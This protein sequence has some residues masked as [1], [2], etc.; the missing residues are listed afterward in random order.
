[1]PF[2]I[3]VAAGEDRRR[4]AGR[5]LLAGDASRRGGGTV[6]RRAS[7]Y[8]LLDVERAR[9]LRRRDPGR[10]EVRDRGPRPDRPPLPRATTRPR[11]CCSTPPAG[12]RTTPSLAAEG[13]TRRAGA[14]AAVAAAAVRGRV[15]TL[16]TRAHPARRRLGRGRAPVAPGRR[17]RRRAG[18]LAA[19][20]CDRGRAVRRRRSRTADPQAQSAAER[21]V[22]PI[23]SYD[24]GDL[25]EDQDGGARL[26]DGGLPRERLRPALRG[27][28][29]QRARAPGPRSR[30]R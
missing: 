21:A 16:R 2:R 11:R 26:H 17:R 20:L 29:G 15:P 4:V 12:R 22:V 1:M 25:D 9:R 6:T 8:D 5:R 14:D 30:P 18:L 27:A 23:L 3:E 19:T 10:V 28:P 7:L 13:P 24:Y